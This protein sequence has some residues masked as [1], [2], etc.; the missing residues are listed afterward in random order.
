MLHKP[1]LLA[2][3]AFTVENAEYAEKGSRIE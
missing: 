1:L 3:E 2:K